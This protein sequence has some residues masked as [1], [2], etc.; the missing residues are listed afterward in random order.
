MFIPTSSVVKPAPAPPAPPAPATTNY[1]PF[2]Y[3]IQALSG[4][5][6]TYQ[7]GRAQRA[8]SRANERLAEMRARDAIKRGQEAEGIS[9]QRTRKVLGSQ[10][11]AQAAQGIRTDYGSPLDIQLE[12]GDI[13][14]LDALT[15]KNNALREAFGHR[16]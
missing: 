9:R 14:E 8:I 6:S 10:R 7:Q 13:G 16:A 1:L 12:T 11:A 5:Y 2:M 15:I 3:G 4:A